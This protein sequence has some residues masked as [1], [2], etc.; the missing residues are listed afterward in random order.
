MQEEARRL[1]DAVRGIEVEEA[2]AE[3]ELQELRGMEQVGA[4]ALRWWLQG[5]WLGWDGGGKRHCILRILL[6]HN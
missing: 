6:L 2:S 5:V 4:G 3:A 1:A